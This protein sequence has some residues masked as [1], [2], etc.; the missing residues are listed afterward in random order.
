MAL[1]ADAR[2]VRVSRSTVDGLRGVAFTSDGKVVYSSN[3]SGA[4]ASSAYTVSSGGG[5]S[6]DR[7]GWRRRP[8]SVAGR[9]CRRD[10]GVP[11]RHRQRHHLS[12]REH[13]EGFRGPRR[14]RRRRAVRVLAR[15]ARFDVIAAPPDGRFVIYTALVAGAPHLFRV[16]PDGSNPT[17]IST[18][19]S[20]MPAVDAA[21]R[22]VA[23]YYVSTDGR[24][25]LGVMPTEGGSHHRH[26]DRAP[27][28]PEP[29]R[30]DER[31]V[32]L[33]AMPDDRA[34]SGCSPSTGR[35]APGDLVRR[36]GAVRLRA[37][38]RRWT[39][40]VVRGPRLRDAQM[41]TGFAG[42]R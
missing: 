32:Y 33:S 28:E 40:A 20:L 29:P 30:A 27:D 18:R 31:G 11:G 5:A 6:L 16:A 8:G 3:T 7:R 9:G 37:V 15:E 21:G 25:R 10:A 42:A 19:P 41:I 22:R 38:A 2:P 35:P 36:P 26:A 12:R 13:A 34:T 1:R 23:F 4:T 14:H 17:Q 39:V 24:Y